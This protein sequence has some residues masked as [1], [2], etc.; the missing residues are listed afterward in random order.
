LI[1]VWSQRA[2]RNDLAHIA[3]DY[4]N[5]KF[6]RGLSGNLTM[7]ALSAGMEILRVE[8]SA[9]PLTEVQQWVILWWLCILRNPASAAIV[10]KWGAKPLVEINVESKRAL[11]LELRLIPYPG[12]TMCVYQVLSLGRTHSAGG[13]RSARPGRTHAERAGY[14]I[15][16]ANARTVE[17]AA[18]GS[19]QPQLGACHGCGSFQHFIRN[20][21]FKDGANAQPR[22]PAPQAKGNFGRDGRDGRD[23]GHKKGAW[24][25]R[26]QG[27]E[28]VLQDRSAA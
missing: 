26:A 4:A 14:G 17:A 18:A 3:L 11:L 24:L 22:S 6:L 12:I 7:D 15:S 9:F 16:H 27:R 25:R 5:N 2:A 23:G 13:A 28:H 10:D 1:A 19:E 20:C 21:P 8:A